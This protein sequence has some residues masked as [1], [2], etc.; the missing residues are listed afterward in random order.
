MVV[1]KSTPFDSA[2]QSIVAEVCVDS[3]R[4]AISH[5]FL[6]RWMARL[7]SEMS[8]LFWRLN[9]LMQ[10]SMS[11]WS[12]SSPPKCVFPAVART[13]KTPLSIESKVTSNVP[14]PSN[15]HAPVTRGEERKE[16]SAT[17]STADVANVRHHSWVNLP[18]SKTRIFSS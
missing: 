6:S 4:L 10:Y 8:T 15:Y 18:K 11:R 12:K 17:G 3:V 1:E 5:C 16:R 7:S 14:P 2:S 9:W 13:S